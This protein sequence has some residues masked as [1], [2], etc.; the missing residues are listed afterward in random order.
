MTDRGTPLPWV[1]ERH[2]QDDG[3][4]NYE[5]WSQTAPNYHRVVTLNDH[6]NENARTDA[7][8]IVTAVSQ[9]DSLVAH[10]AMMA[11]FAGAQEVRL[12]GSIFQQGELVKMLRDLLFWVDATPGCEEHAPIV[13]RARSLL[14][15]V[16]P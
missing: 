15:R 13:E 1:V 14:A 6:D 3:T 7:A 16:D 11:K 12:A 8:I 4:I 10:S 5:I 9:N 2:D